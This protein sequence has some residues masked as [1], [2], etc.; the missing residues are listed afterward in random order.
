MSWCSPSDS[1]AG[2]SFNHATRS[3]N[4]TEPAEGM[5]VR[6]E[7]DPYIVLWLIVGKSGS[8]LERILNG[9]AHVNHPDVEMELH[10]LRAGLAGPNRRSVV[11]FQL[12]REIARCATPTRIADQHVHPGRGTAGD[13]PAQ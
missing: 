10:L 4:A 8:N 6:I 1:P 7:H 3:P 12:E 5:S 11:L 9:G 13:L 2:R